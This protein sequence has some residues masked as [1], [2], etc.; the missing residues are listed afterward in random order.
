MTTFGTRMIGGKTRPL[1]GTPRLPV[2]FLRPRGLR[3]VA[4][5]KFRGIDSTKREKERARAELRRRG[6]K[7]R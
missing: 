1:A 6:L 4:S 2:Q 7:L 3:S 5:G